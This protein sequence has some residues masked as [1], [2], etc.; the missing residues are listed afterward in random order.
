MRAATRSSLLGLLMLIQ[1]GWSR[2][3]W[4]WTLNG[5]RLIALDALAVLPA[6]SGT[7]DAV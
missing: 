4:V 3:S 5:H 7:M 6:V 1:L 2:S